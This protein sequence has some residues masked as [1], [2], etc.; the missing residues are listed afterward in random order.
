MHCEQGG[1]VRNRRISLLDIGLDQGFDTSMGFVQSA[2]QNINAQYEEPVAD[3]DFVR[4]RDPRVV[5][6]AF[7]A[8]CDVLH[9]MAHGDADIQ[10]TF[11]SS[12]G[13]LEVSL[14]DLGEW[15]ADTGL[16]LGASAVI[17][18]G[19]RTGTGTWQRAV[20]DCL[21]GPVVYVGTSS[22]VGWH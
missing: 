18:D 1:P 8:S 21:R 22:M 2:I 3:I 6:S 12:D 10:P 7:T 9:V 14:A 19:C 13:Q 20:R 15:C 16:G 17:A 5:Q 4:S 11:L